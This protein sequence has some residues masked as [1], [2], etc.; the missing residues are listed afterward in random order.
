MDLN[1]RRYPA[2][3][4]AYIQAAQY[5]LNT[6][7]DYVAQTYPNNPAAYVK[8][9]QGVDDMVVNLVEDI[10]QS[11]LMTDPGADDSEEDMEVDQ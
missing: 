6:L 7:F 4:E 9:V 11:G 1:I 2:E 8:A 3:V 5:K 10:E